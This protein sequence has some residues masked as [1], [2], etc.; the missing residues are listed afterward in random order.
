[1]RCIHSYKT[2]LETISLFNDFRYSLEFAEPTRKTEVR[3]EYTTLLAIISKLHICRNVR[4]QMIF[5]LVKNRHSKAIS[6]VTTVKND[7]NL[8]KMQKITHFHR[9]PRRI[10]QQ[11]RP[12]FC[13][14]EFLHQMFLM[15]NP[16]LG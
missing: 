5:Q 8:E 14:T 6:L 12:V 7:A 4:Q 9:S 15:V 3:R 10:N 16:Q 11:N 2:L 13:A 1:M